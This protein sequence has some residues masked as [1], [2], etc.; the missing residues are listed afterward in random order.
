M[1]V[2]NKIVDIETE[3]TKDFNSTYSESFR[4]I[5]ERIAGTI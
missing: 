3:F 2:I 4:E 5:C 1:T